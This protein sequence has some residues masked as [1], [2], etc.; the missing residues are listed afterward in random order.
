M[1]AGHSM[2]FVAIFSSLVSACDSGNKESMAKPPASAVVETRD[3]P[4]KDE[5]AAATQ[6]VILGTGT[7]I[8]DANRAGASIAVIHKG[9]AYV[10]DI[11]AGAVRNATRARYRY[12]IPSLY[13]SQICCVFV[14]HMHGDHTMDYSELVYTLWWRRPGQLQA[15]GPPGMREMTSGMTAMM[16]PDVRTRTSSAQPVPNPE[17]YKVSVSEIEDGFV[18]EKGDLRIEAFEVNH[19]DIRPAFGYRITT[20]DKSIVI[21]GDTAYSDRLLEMARGVDILIHEVISDSGLAKNSPGFQ[22]YH[23]KSHTPA[24]ELGRLASEARPGLLVL[25]HGLYYGVPEN[26]IVDEVR[27]TYDG[28]VVLA[29]DLDIF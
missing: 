2:L 4:S 11:G 22:A 17:G 27:S 9:Q 8:P 14:T 24:S 5:L 29:N 6:V 23:R 26:I 10:F 12:D 28:P 18:F 7:P 13:P 21:S 3:G 20:G 16:A 15:F 1:S 19:G 25:Y